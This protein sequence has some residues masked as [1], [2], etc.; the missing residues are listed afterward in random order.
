VARPA[1]VVAGHLT[2][3][4]MLQHSRYAPKPRYAA[5]CN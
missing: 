1:S 2:R 3:F 5:T 4:A